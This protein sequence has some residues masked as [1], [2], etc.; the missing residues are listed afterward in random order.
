MSR[1]AVSAPARLRR[2]T[3]RS[4][5]LAEALEAAPEAAKRVPPTEELIPGRIRPETGVTRGP[6]K[7]RAP[8]PP[9]PRLSYH[10]ARSAWFQGRTTWPVREAPVHALI[11]ER[12][13]VSSSLPPAPGTAQWESVGPSNVG[14]RLTAV[15]C[16]PTNP[17]R[18]W[19]GAAGGGVWFS[20]NAGQ[21]WQSQWYSQEVL[22]VGA[23]AID[24]RDPDVV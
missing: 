24:P 12:A 7:Q 18:V 6:R 8:G 13:R 20:A 14:G 5:R 9:A 15:A 17:E 19:V 22:N 2:Q 4:A 21:S 3:S 16:H 11:R 10:K 1:R 23:L